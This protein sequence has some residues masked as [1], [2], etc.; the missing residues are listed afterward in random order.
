MPND[1][2]SLKTRSQQNS[3][4]SPSPE[5]TRPHSKL[6]YTTS[7]DLVQGFGSTVA[8]YAK[9]AKGLSICEVGGGRTP[10]LTPEQIAKIEAKYTVLDISDVELSHLPPGYDSV[11]A[12]I[13]SP[14]LSVEPT[15]DLIFSRMLAEHVADG[16]QF[17]SNVLGM[18]QPGGVAIHIFPTLFAMPFIANALLPTWLSMATLEF[19]VPRAQKRRGKFK[20]HYSWCLGPTSSQL[21]RLEGLGYE[22]EEYRC[23]FGH[24]YYRRIPGLRA[25]EASLSGFLR[26]HPVALW[27]S[28]ARVVLRKP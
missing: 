25:V 17:H 3:P 27:T 1:P 16:R 6:S 10:L 26:R 24:G 2:G 5:L 8:Q 23:A 14:D 19:F 15:Y 11:Q 12:D 13:C 7:A 18:L 22:I 21:Q 28:Y 9:A 20:A 4:R